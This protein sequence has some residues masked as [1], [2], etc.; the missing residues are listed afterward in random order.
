MTSL[1]SYL[2]DVR[3]GRAIASPLLVILLD[4]NCTRSQERKRQVLEVAERYGLAGDQVVVGVPD[5]HIERWFLDGPALKKGV[6]P[7]AEVHAPHY[8]CERQRY[9]IALRD[10]FKP[11]GIAPLAGGVEYASDIVPHLALDPPVCGDEA[12]K[13]FANELR[14]AL[15]RLRAAR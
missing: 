9:K 8:K 5:P 7:E 15:R 12:L 6:G 14:A 10:A 2:G 3:R 11:T 1:R 4:G 13:D